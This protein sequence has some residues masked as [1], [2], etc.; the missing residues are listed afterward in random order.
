MP[1]RHRLQAFATSP[2][3]LS[4]ACFSLALRSRSA[5]S[6]LSQTLAFASDRVVD[7]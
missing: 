4:N 6:A 7:S 1:V 5:L 2:A 3:R